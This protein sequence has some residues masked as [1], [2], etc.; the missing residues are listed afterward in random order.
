MTTELYTKTDTG[1]NMSRGWPNS[2]EIEWGKEALRLCLGALILGGIL[3]VLTG[4]YAV[5]QS[6]GIKGLTVSVGGVIIS[7]ILG[8]AALRD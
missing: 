7:Y 2:N 1:G 8:R 5:Y 3:L 4:V 6:S